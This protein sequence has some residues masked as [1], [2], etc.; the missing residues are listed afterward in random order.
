MANVGPLAQG[1]LD[2]SFCLA[3]GAGSI[4][5]SKAVPDAELEASGT[6]V[7]VHFGAA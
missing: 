5:T 6:E 7:A 3:V 4:G 2:E 1:G